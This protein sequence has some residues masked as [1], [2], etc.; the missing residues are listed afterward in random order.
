[1]EMV[2]AR[3]HV[4]HAAVVGI[5]AAHAD[6]FGDNTPLF[7]H[8]RGR[9][10]GVRN[11][12]QQFAETF[13]KAVGAGKEVDRAVACRVGVGVGAEG[14]E[15]PEGVG[16]VLVVKQFMFQKIQLLNLI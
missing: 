4:S 10:V 8:G 5:V 1:M 3:H 16:A 15:T 6:L 9:K 7:R 12:I 11:E 2:E 13:G 14:R